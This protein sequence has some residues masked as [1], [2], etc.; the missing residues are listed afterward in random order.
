MC[1]FFKDFCISVTTKAIASTV[2]LLDL[3]P[4][5]PALK[6]SYCSKYDI[7][8]E[9]IIFSKILLMEHRGEIGLLVSQLSLAPSLYSGM[10]FAILHSFGN[11]P[12][13]KQWLKISERSGLNIFLAILRI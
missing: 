12:F 9:D 6:M 1:L 11:C 8:L 4:Y 5:W 2:D 10:T 7:I 3:K 13:R